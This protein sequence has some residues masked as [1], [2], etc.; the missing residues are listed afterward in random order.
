MSVNR[1]GTPITLAVDDTDCLISDL[2][3][4]DSISLGCQQAFMLV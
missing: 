2:S 4:D 1:R 3:Y